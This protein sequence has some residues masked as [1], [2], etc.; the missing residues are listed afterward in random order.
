[1]AV[2]SLR[3]L[4]AELAGFVRSIVGNTNNP[5][6]VTAAQVNAYTR[7]EIDTLMASKLGLG[8]T[9]LAYWGQSLS[10]TTT[11]T[12]TGGTLKFNKAMMALLGGAKASVPVQNININVSN[13]TVSYLYLVATNGNLSYA[14]T[15]S[16]LPDDNVTMYLGT[17]TGNGSTATL[18]DFTPVIRLGNLRL[19]NTRRGGAIPVSDGSGVVRW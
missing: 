14:A 7:T 15:P 4:L 17:A 16:P 12:I 19:S 5:T 13:G 11:V 18:T 8:D 3:T 6:G 9:P 1:M 2:Q 10:D